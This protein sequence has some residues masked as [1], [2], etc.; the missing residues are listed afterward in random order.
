[1]ELTPYSY[2]SVFKWRDDKILVCYIGNNKPQNLQ[3]K[4]N[5]T[6]MSMSQCDFKQVEQWDLL[7]IEMKKEHL[8]EILKWVFSLQCIKKVPILAITYN[9]DIKDKLLLNNFGIRDYIDGYYDIQVI[10]NKLDD[11]VQMINW[12]HTENNR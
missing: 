9:F 3:G 2:P 11:M 12:K 5:L 8:D 10:H 6:Y 4:Y 7:I 1:M